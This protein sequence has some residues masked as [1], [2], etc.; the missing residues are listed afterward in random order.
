MLQSPFPCEIVG[1]IYLIDFIYLY[2]FTREEGQLQDPTGVGRQDTMIQRGTTRG[3]E[4]RGRREERSFSGLDGLQ[5][6]LREG[7]SLSKGAPLIL[8][9]FFFVHVFVFTIYIVV[10]YFFLRL[11]PQF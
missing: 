8:D 4:R 9:L 2:S 3:R 5:H 10:L 1:G 6:V 7:K 11:S